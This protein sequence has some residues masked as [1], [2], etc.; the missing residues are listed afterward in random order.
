MTQLTSSTRHGF[1]SRYFYDELGQTSC[2][3]DAEGSASDCN[4]PVNDMDEDVLALYTYDE[5]SRIKTYRSY[6]AKILTNTTTYTHD[7][8]DR[9]ETQSE[10]RYDSAA[11]TPSSAVEDPVKGRT[12]TFS[13]IGLTKE[14]AKEVRTDGTGAGIST[15]TYSYDPFGRRVAMTNDSQDA[16]R[17][18][19]S[20]TFTYGYDIHGNVSQLLKTNGD[21]K[22]SYAYGA[23]GSEDTQLTSNNDQLTADNQVTTPTA[24]PFNSYRYS[25]FR[26]DNSSHTI[27]MGARRFGPDTGRFMTA[28]AYSGALSDLGL[29]TDPITGGN[30]YSLAGG[31]PIS[32]AEV[33]GHRLCEATTCHGTNPPAPVGG[34]GSRETPSDGWAVA[35]DLDTRKETKNAPHHQISANAWRAWVRQAEGMA[36]DGDALPPQCYG[37]PGTVGEA[38]RLVP[39]CFAPMVS[40]QTDIEQRFYALTGEAYSRGWT[41]GGSRLG[42]SY[43]PRL[44][45]GVI[46]V[47][48]VVDPNGARAKGGPALGVGWMLDQEEHRPQTERSSLNVLTGCLVV[49][50]GLERT[51]YERDG[52]LVDDD[53]EWGF[54][55]WGLG[56]ELVSL[57]WEWGFGF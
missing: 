23:Y 22:A 33:D 50:V 21:V 3:T 46:N 20:G 37:T 19:E 42:Y 57:E 7:A 9:L 16:T 27:D 6:G 5:L 32:F 51:L 45:A 40:T 12:T 10:T 28:D 2:V 25:G 54:Q 13:Y 44:A 53:T 24:D 26:F 18:G 15:K 52:Q 34:S 1:T 14:V 43:S 49:C 47:G 30:R 36:I 4:A 31:N 41:P 29:S 8:L 39:Q 17:G 11:S 35:A 48:A 56:G 38:R 55:G